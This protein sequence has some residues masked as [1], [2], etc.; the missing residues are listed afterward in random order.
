MLEPICPDTELALSGVVTQREKG[1]SGLDWAWLDL[2]IV[3]GAQHKST[4]RLVIAVPAAPDQTGWAIS[5]EEWQV[6]P[7]S[8]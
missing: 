5:D 7:L 1:P 4:M 8:G 2:A 6:P 3:A